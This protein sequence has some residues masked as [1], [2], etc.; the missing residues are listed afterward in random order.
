MEV[1]GNSAPNLHSKKKAIEP[2]VQM[3]SFLDFIPS[4]RSEHPSWS[5]GGVCRPILC[6]KR[7]GLSCRLTLQQL[8]P[9]VRFVD[10]FFTLE[11]VV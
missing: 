2:S 6:I 7:A 1:M 4:S 3:I 10:S 5:L 9:L 11:K 8:E